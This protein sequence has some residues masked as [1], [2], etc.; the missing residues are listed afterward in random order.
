MGNFTNLKAC[1]LHHQRLG[2]DMEFF[3]ALRNR[4]S[5][6]SFSTQPLENEKLTKVLEAAIAA[7]SA[8]NLQAYEIYVVTHTQRKIALAKA[9]NNQDFLA[10]A[11]AVLVFCASPERS[12]KEYG[13]RG[14]QLYCIQDATIACTYAMLAATA[15]GLASVWIGS[16][17]LD[18]LREAID[19]ASQSHPVAMLPLGYAGEIPEKTS[20]R[21]LASI[22]Q[23]VEPSDYDRLSTK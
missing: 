22:V 14:A 13:D 4:C 23:F 16:F 20:R 10:L 12:A 2:R 11:P 6:R 19:V 17:H 8:G 18:R 5:V 15:L 9:A 1:N 3:A 7:P 21:D